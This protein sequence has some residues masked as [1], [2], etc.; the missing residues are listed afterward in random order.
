MT[1]HTRLCM[2]G[3]V[4]T[5][6]TSRSAYA[7]LAGWLLPAHRELGMCTMALL[8]PCCRL[9]TLIGLFQALGVTARC[10]W[11]WHAGNAV[12]GQEGVDNALAASCGGVWCVCVA[13]PAVA[14]AVLGCPSCVPVL[15]ISCIMKTRFNCI[16][17]VHV[18][19]ASSSV[20]VNRCCVQAK[21]AR[22]LHDTTA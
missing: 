6:Y 1:L 15:N 20:A 21:T 14:C 3:W 17:H 7:S 19:R 13:V 10:D 22:H 5:Q 12:L 8:V 18:Y 9:Q 11:V 16:L 2:T 4:I